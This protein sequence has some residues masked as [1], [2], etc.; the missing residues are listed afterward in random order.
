MQYPKPIQ[1]LIDF[2]RTLPG[3]GTKTA[4]RFVLHLVG[5]PAKERIEFAKAIEEIQNVLHRCR[6]CSRI[7]TRDPC[8]IC[9]D[10]Q[11]DHTTIC[12]VSDQQDVMA[13]EK[14]NEFHGVY[15]V[16][17]GALNPI[18]GITPDRLTID[19]LAER[20]KN[21]KPKVKEIILATNPDIEGESTAMFL[22]RKLKPLH[23]LVSR[24]ARGLPFGSHVE[25]ADD[26]T[27][28]DALKGRARV[29]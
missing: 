3:V 10:S 9:A 8:A 18:E 26:V 23:V 25:Y 16:L 15:H 29:A 11:R 20:I 17:G 13:I 1:T 12:V 24:L 5:I 2:F 19:Q 21:A 6:V 27:L 4:E 22:A 7:D 28:S 14:T